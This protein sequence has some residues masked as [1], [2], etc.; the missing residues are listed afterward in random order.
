MATLGGLPLNVKDDKIAQVFSTV[1]RSLQNPKTIYCVL[2]YLFFFF[3]PSSE[4]SFT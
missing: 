4:N 3:L 2:I 1:Y